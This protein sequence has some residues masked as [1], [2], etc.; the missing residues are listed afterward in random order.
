MTTPRR[1]ACVECRQQKIRCDVEQVRFEILLKFSVSPN[2]SNVFR[3]LSGLCG[4]VTGFL[5]VPYGLLDVSKYFGACGTSSNYL[6]I[7]R[8]RY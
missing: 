6:L 3:G 5:G 4:C 7:Y 2:L 8:S 1:K